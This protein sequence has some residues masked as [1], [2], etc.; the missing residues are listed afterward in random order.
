[1]LR[2]I[3]KPEDV[4]ARLIEDY[5]T[6][7]GTDLVSLVLYGSAASGHYIPGRSDLNILVILTEA[8]IE[9]L[10][11][12]L[13]VVTKWKKKKVAVIFMTKEYMAR[14]LDAFPVE[15]IN[16][17]MNHKVLF[18]EDA[19]AGLKFED[20]DLRLQLERELKGKIFHLQ[21]GFLESEGREKGLRRLIGLS[22]G[23]FVPLFKALLY[24]RG[25]DVPHGRREVIKAIASTYP[26]DP[27]I[28]LRC[29]DI[30]EGRNKFAPGEIKQLYKAYQKE[31][32]KLSCLIDGMEAETAIRG[33]NE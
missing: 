16:M 4:F 1:M 17:Q 26:I 7:F 32:V 33:G 28:F 2:T 9:G 3:N 21:H 29:A 6:A 8:G 23:S 12:G 31:I 15:F 11:R 18:G 20:H 10:G 27:D 25:H 13:P 14:S 19:L 5:K 24:L 22:L 30:R